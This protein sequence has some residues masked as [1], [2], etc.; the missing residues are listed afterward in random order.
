MEYV[1]WLVEPK[2]ALEKVARA[3][4]MMIPKWEVDVDER[5]HGELMAKEDAER[6]L[7]C[8]FGVSF[9][10]SIIR[11]TRRSRDSIMASSCSV[12]LLQILQNRYSSRRSI[13]LLLA[14]RETKKAGLEP[15]QYSLAAAHASMGDTLP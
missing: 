5:R 7:T 2:G 6:E 14:C 4:V 13:W 15:H 8:S 1:E 10:V 9:E 11:D 3:Q 12:S